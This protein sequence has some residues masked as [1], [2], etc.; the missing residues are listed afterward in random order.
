LPNGKTCK[1]DEN[2]N[3]N[4]LHGGPLG[5]SHLVWDSAAQV[6][7]VDLEITTDGKT[8]KGSGVKFA[9]VSED[10]EEGFPGMLSVEVGYYIT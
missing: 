5:Y 8:K 9:R 1:L 3:G 7:D 10:G 2:N 6:K 4:S